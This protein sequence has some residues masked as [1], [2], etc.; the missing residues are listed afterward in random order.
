SRCVPP[1]R[2]SSLRLTSIASVSGCDF[3]RDT[4]MT[5]STSRD[6]LLPYFFPT[7][8]SSRSAWR[9]TRRTRS[10]SRPL[11]RCTT[12]CGSTKRIS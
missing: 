1:N 2:R 8:T 6:F 12:P 11:P 10:S 3:T 9:F 7:S 5:S 4:T